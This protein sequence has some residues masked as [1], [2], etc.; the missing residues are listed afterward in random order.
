M[1]ERSQLSF[2]DDEPLNLGIEQVEQKLYNIVC[3]IDAKVAVTGITGNHYEFSGAGAVVEVAEADVAGLL[4][5]RLGGRSCCGGGSP[6]G[7][8]MFLLQPEI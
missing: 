6:D 7:N 3:T 2:F 1:D 8:V 5:K 4:A